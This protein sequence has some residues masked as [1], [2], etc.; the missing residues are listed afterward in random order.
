[1]ERALS[2]DEKIRRA[3][4]IY[5][6]RKMM[7]ESSN[8]SRKGELKNQKDNLILKKMILQILICIVIY[9]IFYMIKNTSYIFSAD[10]INKT[11]E[12][13]I[14]KMFTCRFLDKET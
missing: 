8:Y 1:M 14:K 9:C 5:Y 12:Q 2:P 10:V 13:F 3:E 11:K 6:R 4:E 7:T